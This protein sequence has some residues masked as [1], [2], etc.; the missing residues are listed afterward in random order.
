MSELSTGQTIVAIA[1][2]NVLR[3]VDITAVQSELMRQGVPDHN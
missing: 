3:E 1:S 2:G